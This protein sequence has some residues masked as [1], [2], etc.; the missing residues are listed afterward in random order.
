VS[1]FRER[2]VKRAIRSVENAG[3]QVTAVEI[4][5]GKIVVVVGTPGDGNKE[6]ELDTWIEKHHAHDA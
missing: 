1:R 4:S 6:T 3:K 5:D 2:D